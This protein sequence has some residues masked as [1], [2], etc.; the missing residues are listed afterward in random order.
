M[1]CVFTLVAF[2]LGFLVAQLSKFISGVVRTNR[3]GR[4]LDFREAIRQFSRSGGMPSGHAA[5]LTAATTYLGIENGF[6]SGLFALAVCVC[7]IVLYDAV[8]VRYAVGEQGKALNK[9][10][11]E[12]DKPKLPVVEGH[13][14]VQVVVGVVIGV[15]I[16]GG[17]GFVAGVL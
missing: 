3:V 4:K 11:V 6:G 13:T 16:G 14:L 12:A 7:V 2:T 1:E 9:L 10:L 17:V 8:H 15:L 5:S